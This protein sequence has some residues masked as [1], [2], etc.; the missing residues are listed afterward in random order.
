MNLDNIC[1]NLIQETLQ[2]GDITKISISSVTLTGKTIDSK[3]NLNEHV[4]NRKKAYYK[5]YAAR[6]L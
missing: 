3:L 6:R 4:N 5:L 2:I 1:T